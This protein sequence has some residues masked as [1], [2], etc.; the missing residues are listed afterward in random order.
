MTVHSS[1]QIES[2]G[3]AGADHGCTIVAEDEL[4]VTPLG[5]PFLQ[6]WELADLNENERVISG[7]RTFDISSG[8]TIDY[9]VAC[10]KYDDAGN[11]TA[12]ITAMAMTALFTPAPPDS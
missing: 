7:F 3:P 12:S 8:A 2:G 9:L 10:Q 6:Y 5:G 1:T 4:L 11:F